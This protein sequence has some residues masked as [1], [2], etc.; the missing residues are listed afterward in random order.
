MIYELTN[1]YQR[2]LKSPLIKVAFNTLNAIG[3]KDTACVMWIQE[4]YVK[5]TIE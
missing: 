1:P 4:P 2:G 5:I 3:A